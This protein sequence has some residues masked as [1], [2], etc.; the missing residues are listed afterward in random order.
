MNSWT[1]WKQPYS[2]PFYSAVHDVTIY[3]LT[4]YYTIEERFLFGIDYNLSTYI[5][6]RDLLLSFGQS[7]FTIRNNKFHFMQLKKIL[8]L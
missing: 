8:N 4:V 1:N 5:I 6:M 7:M 3:Y 2:L